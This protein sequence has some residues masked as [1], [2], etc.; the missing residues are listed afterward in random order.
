MYW[1]DNEKSRNQNTAKEVSAEEGHQHP[2]RRDFLPGRQ[3]Q[4]ECF[5]PGAQAD[6]GP[7]K[8][9]KADFLEESFNCSFKRK[10]GGAKARMES[11]GIGVSPSTQP[12]ELWETRA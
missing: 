4:R 5:T 6:S 10:A 9:K 7:E 11:S 1:E 8:E 2:L 12:G 3:E